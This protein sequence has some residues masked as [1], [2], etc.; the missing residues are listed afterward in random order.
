MNHRDRYIDVNQ[1]TDTASITFQRGDLSVSGKTLATISDKKHLKVGVEVGWV[2]FPAIAPN[3]LCF[4]SG[5]ISSWVGNDG[6]CFVDGVAI[7]GVSGG[8]AFYVDNDGEV[9]IIG[10]VSA[11]RA[12]SSD[13]R[14]VAW[15]VRNKRRCA[16]SVNDSGTDE[17]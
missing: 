3:N 8:P 13:G 14:S 10:V 17:S 11:L 4:F 16:S 12:E 6:F 5:T 15:V 1:S 9:Q 7:N 2:G